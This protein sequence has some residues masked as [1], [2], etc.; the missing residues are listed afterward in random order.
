MF[1][2]AVFVVVSLTILRAFTLPQHLF[3][4]NMLT[5]VGMLLFIVAVALVVRSRSRRQG[6]RKRMRR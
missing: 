3:W 1:I 2:N 4:P 5:S 6:G